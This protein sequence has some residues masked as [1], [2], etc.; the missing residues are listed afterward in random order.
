MNDVFIHPRDH[1][2]LVGTHGRSIWQLPFR[3]FEFLTEA[4]LAKPLYVAP[5]S[6]VLYLGR[7]P[8]GWFGGDRGWAAPNS[9]PGTL[10]TYHVNGEGAERANIEILRA[11]GTRVAQL[12]GP[13]TKGLQAVS[14]RPNSAQVPAG[15]YSVR[16]TVGE[17]TS[18]NSVKI[19]D[20]TDTLN[21]EVGLE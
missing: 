11:D 8:R 10:I 12:A 19:I 16:V 4:N 5:A 1:D 7:T 6:D 17:E 15:D 13:G 21:H 9:Q 14:W 3:V 18:Q 2:A 20:L